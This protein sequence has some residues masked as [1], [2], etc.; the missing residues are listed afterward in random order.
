MSFNVQDGIYQA[1]YRQ[2]SSLNA[3][4]QIMVLLENVLKTSVDHDQIFRRDLD[5]HLFNEKYSIWVI[6]QYHLR[7][8]KFPKINQTYT[9][10]T[11]VVQL[12]SFFVARYFRVIQSDQVC[13]EIHIQF[14]GIDFKERNVVRL[15]TE[16]FIQADLIDWDQQYKF[17]KI[18]L[19]QGLED[20]PSLAYAIK[21]SD[22][23]ENQHVNNLVYIRWCLEAM[24]Q[25]NIDWQLPLMVNV[26]YGQEILPQAQILIY[27]DTNVQDNQK[28]TSFKIKNLTT[29]DEASRLEFEWEL[30]EKE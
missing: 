7:L 25:L 26:K 9:I 18:K 1:S 10:D 3:Q 23:D 12:N 19:P 16:K 14:V 15:D 21:M 27:A 5:Q 20:G 30:S 4:E 13:A 28:K 29:G 11:R 22:I 2:A 6:T 17:R 24:K 8:Y